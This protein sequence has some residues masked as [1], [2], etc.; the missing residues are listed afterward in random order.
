L[1]FKILR[2]VNFD[3]LLIYNTGSKSYPRY[4]FLFVIPSTTNLVAW[5]TLAT[6]LFIKGPF[7]CNLS[8]SFCAQ[9]ILNMG[10]LVLL[11]LEVLKAFGSHLILPNS[12]FLQLW[13]TQRQE[14]KVQCVEHV[15][16][17]NLQIVCSSILISLPP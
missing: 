7:F 5:V 12:L 6:S 3:P 9:P 8:Y 2:A 17:F 16:P 15:N 4:Q 14:S 10:S 11:S 1:E 13:A